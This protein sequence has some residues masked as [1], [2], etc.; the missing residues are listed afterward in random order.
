MMAHRVIFLAFALLFA[1]AGD[2]A[3]LA[4][5]KTIQFI[6][7]FG[8][9]SGP[10]VVAR[11]LAPKIS[12]SLGDTVIVENRPGG[13]G[14]IG[15]KA[16][17]E[18]HDGTTVLVTGASTMT[19][20]PFLYSN[21][22]Y[23]MKD[24]RLAA[25]V[26]E[27]AIFLIASSGANVQNVGDLIKL[28]KSQPGKFNYAAPSGT[29]HQMAGE[30]FT[31]VTGLDWTRINYRD[32]AQALNEI[33]SGAVPFAFTLLPSVQ[34]ALNEGRVR[35]IGVT[36]PQRQP[37]HPDVPSIGETVA[38]YAEGDFFGLFVP[39]DVPTAFVDKLGAATATALQSDEIKSRFAGMA[40]PVLSGDRA[41]YEARME[42]DAK[43]RSALIKERHLTMD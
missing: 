15:A 10:D 14:I 25:P 41:T 23:S 32:P 9:G 42:K 43:Q 30:L 18:K 40:L 20:T 22:D 26:A 35:L 17:L 13:A 19:M 39:A 8:P 24:F 37:S 38:G 2:R 36:S 27:I 4:Q 21:P 5:S 12:E 7:Q 6:V 1:V 11:L 28:V 34:Q 31:Q 33:V 29:P 16:A 3:A